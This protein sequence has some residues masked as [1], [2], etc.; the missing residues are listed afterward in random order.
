MSNPRI[1]VS[2]T[3]RAGECVLC[4]Q[5]QAMW[6]GPIEGMWR[7][8]FDLIVVHPLDRERVDRELREW[9]ETGVAIE[10]FA[11]RYLAG[12]FAGPHPSE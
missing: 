10:A 6:I 9:I 8:S 7:R 1:M 12:E 2:D 5:D 3:V 4:A 11:A